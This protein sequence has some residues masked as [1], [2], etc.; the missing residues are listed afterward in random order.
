MGFTMIENKEYKDLILKEKELE[1]VKKENKKL[2]E[3]EEKSKE[4]KKELEGELKELILTI[5]DNKTSFY[6]K[7]ESYAIEDI[8]LAEYLN[9]YYCN[10]GRLEYRKRKI[11]DKEIVKKNEK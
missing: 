2:K 8:K 9:Q 1:E 4:A 6:G 10:N 7:I 3:L 5:T 11:E